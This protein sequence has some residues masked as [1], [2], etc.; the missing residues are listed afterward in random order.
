MFVV[1]F[2]AFIGAC[3]AVCCGVL[4]TT[5]INCNVKQNTADDL[6]ESISYAEVDDYELVVETVP[7]SKVTHAPFAHRVSTPLVRVL[8]LKRRGRLPKRN[9]YSHQC[10]LPL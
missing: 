3:C 9:W 7:K 1:L 8:M 2:A 4:V 10:S 6:V 5:G